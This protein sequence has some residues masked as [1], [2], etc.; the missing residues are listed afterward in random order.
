M[1]FT[2]HKRRQAPGVII[3]SLIDI[4]I[5]LLIFLITT[6][7]FRQQPSL[8]LALPESRQPREGSADKQRNIIV[9]IARTEPQFFIDTIPVTM[10]KL[11]EEL[12]RRAA[13]NPKISL[14]IRADK[15]ATWDAIVKVMDAAKSA[16][17]AN[18]S[19]YTKPPGTK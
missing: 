1:K 7:T 9:T 16:K 14:A 6:M 10:T 19:A 13:A 17:I 2:S 8:K 12:T 4:L 15:D 5:V 11:Q 18:V 3:I